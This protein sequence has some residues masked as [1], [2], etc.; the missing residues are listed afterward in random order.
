MP[1]CE[2]VPIYFDFDEAAVRKDQKKNIT[3]NVNCMTDRSAKLG[4]EINVNLIGHA[5]EMG[6][7]DYNVELGH[8]R[9]KAIL[10]EVSK[11]GIKK[12]RLATDSRGKYEPVVRCNCN[13]E[14][15]RRVEFKQK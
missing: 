15:N 1:L 13:E 6:P 10:K 2:M 9:A 3:Q 7:E 12:D 8:D 5:D 11:L 14:K 4:N